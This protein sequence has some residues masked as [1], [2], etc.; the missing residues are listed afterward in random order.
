MEQQG[1]KA[2]VCPPVTLQ[3]H[4]AT[5]TLYAQHYLVAPFYAARRQQAGSSGSRLLLC[6]LVLH[7]QADDSV[8]DAISSRSSIYEG[9]WTC[10]E[11]TLVVVRA[12]VNKAPEWSFVPSPN[13]CVA[14][15]VNGDERRSP[16]A[17]RAFA[18]EWNY[19]FQVGGECVGKGAGAVLG[20][21]C[22][23]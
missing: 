9:E 15:T 5:C 17:R 14:V 6:G 23:E 19:Q 21:W 2:L 13:L 10:G 18:H 4:P 22:K 7:P 16:T 8:Q 11:L 3:C 1:S 12:S 20:T